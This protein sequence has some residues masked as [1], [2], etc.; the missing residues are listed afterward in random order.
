AAFLLIA[1]AAFAIPP[2]VAAF[3]SVSA[4]MTRRTLGAEA[5]LAVRSLAGSLRRTSVLTGA[6]CTAIAMTAAVG[7]MVGS[8]RQTV[9]LWM[10]DRLQADL[11]IRPAG[12]ASADHHPTLS[13]D[14]AGRL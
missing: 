6:L 13:P 2:L 12:P 8:F 3:S 9:V 7:I 5:L 10:N 4:G 14:T 11:Y 1:A